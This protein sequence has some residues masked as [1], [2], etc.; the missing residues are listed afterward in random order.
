MVVRAQEININSAIPTDS[1]V[2][3]SSKASSASSIILG[4]VFSNEV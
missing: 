4:R 3:V 2:A 1:V